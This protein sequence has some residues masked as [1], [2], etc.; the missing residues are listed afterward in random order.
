M[1]IQLFGVDFPPLYKEQD[2]IKDVEDITAIDEKIN[3]L[4]IEREE[5]VKALKEKLKNAN[6]D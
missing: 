3:E 5:R 6:K 4:A 2:I 1:N